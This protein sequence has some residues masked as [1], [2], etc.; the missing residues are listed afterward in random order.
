[1]DCAHCHTF[2]SDKFRAI[3]CAPAGVSRTN[4]NGLNNRSTILPLCYIPHACLGSV[5]FV[6]SCNLGCLSMFAL[7]ALV[8]CEQT[9]A[10]MCG[11]GRALTAQVRHIIITI[12][13]LCISWEIFALVMRP[14]KTWFRQG[15]LKPVDLDCWFVAA[16]THTHTSGFVSSL[17]TCHVSNL[18]KDTFPDKLPKAEVLL[19]QVLD[20]LLRHPECVSFVDVMC[21]VAH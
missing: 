6:P 17:L 19:R 9:I 21:E 8:S 16:H 20:A 14:I 11:L 15:Y 13:W 10:N 1:M 12:N 4:V 3:F 7:Q 18:Q 5:H 2:L